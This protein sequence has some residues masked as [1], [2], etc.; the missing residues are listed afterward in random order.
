M[1]SP[2]NPARLA[3]G[4]LVA[5]VSGAAAQESATSRTEQEIRFSIEVPALPNAQCE[6]TTST[7]YDQRNTV[8]RVEST[9][10]VEGC[11]A[12]GGNFTVAVRVRDDNGTQQTLEFEET[13]QRT[14]DQDVRLAADYPIGENVELLS[15]R[16]RGM[17]CTCA[18]GGP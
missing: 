12:A 11:A 18:E 16:V 7:S 17:S 13:W 9:I 15:V 10:A 2:R 5:L 3:L 4:A 14:D 1:R 8:A 6:A